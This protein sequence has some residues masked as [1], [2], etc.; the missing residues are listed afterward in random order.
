[1]NET[2][3]LFRTAPHPC[4]YKEG[5]TAATVFV[6]PELVIDTHLNSR[7]SELGYRRSGAHLYR[8]D[9]EHC[10]ACISCRIPVESFSRSK[11]F[12]RI[13]NRNADLRIIESAELD[14]EQAYPLYET[15]I[16]QR[17]NDGDMYPATPEQFEAFICN[18]P[19][20]SRYY[21]FYQ[22]KTLVA[23]AVSD[24]FDTGLSAVYTFFDPRQ[25]KR[26]LGNYAILWQI[27]QASVANLP[28]L[29][30]GYW[31]KDCAK[32]QYK[33]AFRPLEMLVEGRW[34]LVK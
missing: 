8:P 12:Q 15:Y 31:I 1:M 16:G 33:S 26:S 27:E 13:W 4:S 6:D 21:S 19:K 3:R 11:R 5:E 24:V 29:Y 2:I 17:H 9:C 25:E 28:Y 20:G 7:L 23:V 18:K 32:M 30:L 34:V 22:G 10:R 14:D